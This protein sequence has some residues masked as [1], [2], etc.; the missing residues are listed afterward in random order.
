MFT[1]SGKSPA[2]GPWRAIRP[3]RSAN[4]PNPASG[5][6]ASSS[7]I[8]GAACGA[9]FFRLNYAVDLR[10]GVLVDIA[11]KVYGGLPVELA[12]PAFN[13]I[14]QRDANSYAL[15]S[16]QHCA[17][18]PVVLN[19]TGPET[20]RVRDTANWFAGRFNR[21]C[22][23]EGVEGSMALLSNASACMQ[24]LG[25]PQLPVAA[26]MR[27]VADW[28]AGGGASLDKPTHFEVSDGRF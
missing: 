14:W 16:L 9:C 3:R 19:V 18:P 15:R 23:F 25:K 5:V 7:T 21:T 24:L 2:A 22:R 11:R 6:S 12:V 20:L 26:L 17:S 13:V 28:V 4:T 1:R 10:Y 8:R 27:L